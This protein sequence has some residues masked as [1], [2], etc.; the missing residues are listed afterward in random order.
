MPASGTLFL[1]DSRLIWTPSILWPLA[2]SAII[3]KGSITTIEKEVAGFI[4]LRIPQGWRLRTNKGDFTF[5]LGIFAS[6][7]TKNHWLEAINQWA[8]I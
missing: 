1:T 5:S 6:G 4:A 2:S 8:N 3:E 7:S